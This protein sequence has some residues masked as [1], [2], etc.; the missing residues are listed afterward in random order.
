MQ[1]MEIADGVQ[2]RIVADKDFDLFQAAFEPWLACAAKAA[3]WPGTY[4][5]RGLLNE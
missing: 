3:K 2:L 1:I 4:F 5:F